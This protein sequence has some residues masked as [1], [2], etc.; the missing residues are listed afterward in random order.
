MSDDVKIHELERELN[1]MR[2]HILEEKVK[3]LTRKVCDLE[4]EHDEFRVG[5]CVRLK[6]ANDKRTLEVTRVTPK[7][8]WVRHG[9][10]KPFLKRK[11]NV[12]KV[13]IISK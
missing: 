10:G 7:S 5:N 2:I 3:I 4:N 12:E 13:K 9:D 1:K 6:D 11:Y 8:L